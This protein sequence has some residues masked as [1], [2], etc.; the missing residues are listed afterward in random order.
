M[1]MK[2]TLL[3]FALLTASLASRADVTEGLKFRMDFTNV[4]GKNVT[5][6]LSGIN[7]KVTGSATVDKM[8]DY[9][10]LNLGNATGY[11]DLTAATGELLAGMGNYTVSVYYRVKENTSLSGNGHFLWAFST[12]AACTSTGGAYT[13]YRLNAQ[14]FASSTGGYNNE[15]GYSVGTASE[16]GRWIHVAVTQTGTTGR[17]YID[18]VLKGTA[19]G[20]ATNATLYGAAKPQCCWV[21]RPHFSGD[22]YLKNTLVADLRLYD[23]ALTLA[24]IKELAAETTLLDEAYIHGTP[25]DA[26][27]LLTTIAQAQSLLA[28]ADSYLPDAV[29]DLE[30]ML[31]VAETVAAGGYSQDYINNIRTQLSQTISSV[32]ATSNINL[33]TDA[34]VSSNYDTDRGFLHPGGLHTQAD[35]DRI[36]QQIADKNT[37]VTQ[38][39]NKLKAAA[40]AQPS[41]A[42]Y[43]VETIVRG[44][45]SGENYIN[46]ARGATIAYQNALRWKIEG[47][48]ACARHAVDVLMQ[49]AR[50]TKSIGGDSNYAL[51]V[52]L[53]GY[54]FAQAAE[55]MRD[56]EGWSATDFATFRQWML[57]VWYTPAIGFLRSRNGTW[58]NADK[59]WQ[60]PGHYWSNWGLCNALCMAS[61]GVLC[62]DVFIY[63]QAMSYFKYD[64]VGTFKNP[65]TG[66]LLRND[67][68]TEFLGNLVVTTADS[69][70][71]TGAYGQLGQMNESGRDT[72]H[73]AMALGLAID[74]AKLGWN[75]GDDLFAYM[76]H[77]LAAGIE[78]V[79]A[80]TQSVE[81]LPWVNY[82]YYTNGLYYT[83][84]RTWTMTGPALGAQMRPYWGTVVGIYE[85]VKGVTMPFAEVSL[86]NMGID[87]GGQGSTSGGYDHLGYSV[88]M[89]TRDV[90]LCPSEQVPTEL[91][92]KMEYS[93]TLTAN[94]IPSLSVE[95]T[96]GNI[97]GQTI[98]HNELGGLVNT[99]QPNNRTCVPRG[100]TL[101]LMPQLP[102]GEEDT[103]LW[104]WETGEQTRQLTVTTNR[105]QVYR[106]T[107]TNQN[108]VTSQLSFAIAAENDCTPAMLTP[109]IS[110]GTRT[111]A[112]KDT[113]T[114]AYGQTA[115]LAIA[116]TGGWG[117]CQWSTGQTTQT[118]TTRPI[119]RDRDYTVYYT[120]QG[121]AISGHTFHI[122][123]SGTA[124]TSIRQVPASNVCKIQQT[125]HYTPDGRQVARPVSGITIVSQTRAD[126][127]IH[128]YKIHN[129]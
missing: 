98:S 115:T 111:L 9:R 86:Q 26:A 6:D 3:F 40:Y 33:P 96:L 106:V 128:T 56:Y 41:A 103:G 12:S 65:R 29:A 28:D 117:S 52:G 5:D 95:R 17:L 80:Q 39:Y 49:W 109:T 15:K 88:L 27:Q 110:N 60:A 68:L 114:V 70:M 21:G 104:Q 122:K 125:R 10:V 51:A 129:R 44:G 1:I 7:A 97:S 55:L 45:G 74:L 101:T 73:S 119:V 59:W 108:G 64:Q 4:E 61:I 123:V 47:N 31:T 87:E 113:I 102:D 48:S 94:L 22:N 77:R 79:A 16:S 78:Y 107:Y 120:N 23:R 92:G 54:Q 11:L 8:G 83:D 43:P 72:G 67:G 85:G 118:I 36:R 37:R 25:G 57:D 62:D 89:N 13:A 46:A 124:P 69:D 58:E 75:Q 105:S 63:N 116:A 18:G 99:F 76:D 81:G 2:K 24:Q 14:R 90:Q 84:S 127:T 121:A 50:T 34:D 93:G 42:T 53:Y 126:G 35:F 82:Q 30:D 19:T 100:E 32:K 66:D 71:E 38:A 112:G 91:T 20:M